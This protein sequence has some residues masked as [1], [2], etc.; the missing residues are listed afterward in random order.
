MSI[1]RLCML[2]FMSKTASLHHCSICPLSKQTRLEFPKLSLSKTLHPFHYCIWTFG[3]SLEPLRIM[4][5]DFSRG[6]W[7]YL[8]HSKM[9]ILRVLKN[10]LAM[11]QTQFNIHVKTIRTDNALDF[12]KLE[13]TSLLS[14][15]GILHQSSCPYT[16]QQNGVVER[17]ID[18]F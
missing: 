8:M 3:A 5:G 1:S 10:F 6:T 4:G 11:V 16:P 14:S 15:L 17:K 9:D 7:V 2:P 12:F 13:C 18:I